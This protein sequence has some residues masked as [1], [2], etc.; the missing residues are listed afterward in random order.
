[1]SSRKAITTSNSTVPSARSRPTGRQKTRFPPS[2]AAD[3]QPQDRVVADGVPGRAGA[4]SPRHNRRRLR[5]LLV[6]YFGDAEQ[7]AAV[8]QVLTDT[9][10][11]VV[12]QVTHGPDAWV[13]TRDRAGTGRVHAEH[14]QSAVDRVA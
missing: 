10:D 13:N 5:E 14:R 9:P 7:P 6:L 8:M 3:S 2:R 11:Q 12:W 1:M 4:S